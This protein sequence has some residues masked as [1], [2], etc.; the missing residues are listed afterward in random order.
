MRETKV[1]PEGAEN[2]EE[3]RPGGVSGGQAAAG[4]ELACPEAEQE[5]ESLRLAREAE[6]LAGMASR[7]LAEELSGPGDTKRAK[8][9]SGIFKDMAAL[10]REL[11]G[12]GVPTL[13]V[14]FEGEAAE[15]GD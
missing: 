7:L 12:A 1:R 14:R 8:E 9:L 5:S 10:S 2:K 3:I 6:A 15:A 13:T 4:A 11:G